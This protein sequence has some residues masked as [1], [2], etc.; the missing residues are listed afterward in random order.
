[1]Q[2]T[3]RRAGQEGTGSTLP[4]LALFRS[5]GRP[6]RP[7]ARVLAALRAATALPYAVW[8]PMICPLDQAADGYHA[9][10]QRR[11]HQAA[12][13][14]QTALLRWEGGTTCTQARQ[15]LGWLAEGE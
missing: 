3:R 10:D 5:R 1:M 2:S 6:R 8:R 12:A 9:M 15:L 11:A 14:L 4:N 13:A 7:A